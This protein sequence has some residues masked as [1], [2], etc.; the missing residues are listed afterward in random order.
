[1]VHNRPTLLV[2]LEM[3]FVRYEMHS[4]VSPAIFAFIFTVSPFALY[5]ARLRSHILGESVKL[6]LTGHRLMPSCFE[7]WC[8]RIVRK[9]NGPPCRRCGIK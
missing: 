8:G 2:P 4:Y 7:A 6:C 9:R 3:K 5:Y 1:M